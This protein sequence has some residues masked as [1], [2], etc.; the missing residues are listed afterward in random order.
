MNPEIYIL[1][2]KI[3]EILKEY[4]SIDEN[5]HK[6]VVGILTKKETW[7][8]DRLSSETGFS[9]DIEIRHFFYEAIKEYRDSEKSKLYSVS[10]GILSSNETWFL[11]YLL[12]DDGILIKKTKNKSNEENICFKI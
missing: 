6:S 11:T 3:Y 10:S 9:N 7:L 8:F 5:T 12:S 1:E 2:N 4:R